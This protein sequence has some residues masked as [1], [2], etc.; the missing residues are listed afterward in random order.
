M[1]FVRNLSKKFV[2]VMT[3]NIPPVTNKY[4]AFTNKPVLIKKLL[5]SSYITKVGAVSDRTN[6]M[7]VFLGNF[8][9]SLYANIIRITIVPKIE[10]IAIYPNEANS[11]AKK[12]ILGIM[13][14]SIGKN[15][16]QASR[17]ED[18]LILKS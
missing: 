8:F 5:E 14:L 17:N 11:R 16:I 2:P 13:L 10:I 1:V 7:K 15:T 4:D 6:D 18:S 9:I 3:A 12:S